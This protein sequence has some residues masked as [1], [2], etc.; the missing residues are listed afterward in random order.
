MLPA[1]YLARAN[2]EKDKIAVFGDAT[3]VSKDNPPQ[4]NFEAN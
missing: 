4:I 1:Q 3:G 2:S